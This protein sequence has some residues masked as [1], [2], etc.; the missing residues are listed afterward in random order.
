M[1]QTNLQSAFS[2]LESALLN[3][4]KNL[5]PVPSVQDDP[6]EVIRP[7]YWSDKV[8]IP[9]IYRFSQSGLR[10]YFDVKDDNPELS[11]QVVFYGG[12]TT[13]IEKTTPTGYGLKKLIGEL[14][15][16]GFYKMM[17]EKAHYGTLLHLLIADYL[18][19]S[20]NPDGRTFDF[21]SIPAR[22][23][24][25]MK[26]FKLDYDAQDWAWRVKK[27]LASL[28]Q[29]CIDHEVE[30]LIIEGTG[31][32]TDPENPNLRFAGTVDMVCR[33]KIREKGFWGE[34]YKSGE[35][36]GEAK[37]SF[38]EVWI[39]A[40]VDFKSGKAGFFEDHEIQLHMYKLI[41]E[42]SYGVLVD[43][44][45]NV[46]PADWINEPTY[47]L[48]DQS[49][50]TAALKIPYLLRLFDLDWQEPKDIL[51]IDGMLNGDGLGSVCRYVSAKE[52]VL[53]K[54]RTRLNNDNGSVPVK[55]AKTN[56]TKNKQAVTK[57]SPE[58]FNFNLR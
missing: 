35:R 27:D 46:A 44:V 51:V 26:D 32:Y 5:T 55:T 40:A 53:A 13:V 50:S 12:C 15:I 43:K 29:F 36:K 25:Y 37:E 56:G 18:R 54:L 17:K 42:H 57:L 19:S 39:T 6:I 48:K 3:I 41:V 7:V 11:P 16:S 28:V 30:P 20:G 1:N 10:F 47:K 45:Y 58:Y 21:S 2:Q 8:T 52:W 33:M 49:E 9:T 14:G 38:K 4:S 31:T 34:V 23:A 22:T 24:A